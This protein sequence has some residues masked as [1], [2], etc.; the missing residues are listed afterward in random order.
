MSDWEVRTGEESIYN[1][2]FLS[3]LP[4]LAPPQYLDRKIA[5]HSDSDLKFYSTQLG[6]TNTL[7][8][9]TPDND[10]SSRF[11][12][13]WSP[14]NIPAPFIDPPIVR[15]EPWASSDFVKSSKKRRWIQFKSNLMSC[16]K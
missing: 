13:G 2:E 4:N 5:A 3:E 16:I 7:K 11:K 15:S 9:I 10:L 12:R 8:Q 1:R 14:E 6:L